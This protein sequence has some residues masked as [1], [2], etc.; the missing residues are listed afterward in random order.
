MKTKF[1]LVSFLLSFALYSVA[2]EAQSSSEAG[3]KTAFKHSRAGENWFI[4]IGGGGQIYFAD[5]ND[6][7]PNPTHL[8]TVVPVFALGKWFSPYWGVR[9]KG[10]G[11]ALDG[12]KRSGEGK[13]NLYWQNDDY[14]NVHLDAMW[15]LSNYW[16]VYSPTKVFNFTP[17]LG[18]GFAH[19]FENKQDGDRKAAGAFIPRGVRED[20]QWL[21]HG[22]WRRHADAISVNAGIQF[23]FRLSKHV[24]LDFDL[25]A[26]IVP[27]YFD[28]VFYGRKNEVITTATA[29][30]TFK[31]GK[32]D[33]DV[34]AALDYGLIDD[35][36]GKINSLRAEN[37]KLSK[38]PVSCPKCPDVAPVVKSEIN[39]VPNV[40]FFRINS[41]KVDENQKVGIYNTAEF[42]K[43]TGEKIKVIGY[44]DKKTGTAKYNEDLSRRRAQ[45]VAKELTT[46]YKI[47][48]SKITVSWNGDKVQPYSENS[49]NRV[50]IMSAD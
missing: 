1:I 26:A 22:G 6:L 33:F 38:R 29:G 47:P 12:V 45:A 21:G 16:G 8:A 7:A 49:W 34:V 30:L 11:G 31:L 42:V 24:N 43:N 20:D 18:L 13:D 46:K 50:V 32:T 41:D 9:L 40:V 27:D 3:Y 36:N 25:G 35:L 37:E 17:Y 14:L 28:G 23:G 44:A 10:Q 48:S 5:Q 19:K 2:Q 15:N 4:H 39:Y